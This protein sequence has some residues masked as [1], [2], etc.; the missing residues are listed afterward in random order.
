MAI[1][2]NLNILL[3]V[4]KSKISWLLRDCN[5]QFLIQRD[6]AIGRFCYRIAKGGGET[7]GHTWD[8]RIIFFSAKDIKG[9]LFTLGRMVN[10]VEPL[11]A[12]KPLNPDELP[13]QKLKNALREVKEH[14]AENPFITH[15]PSQSCSLFGSHPGLTAGAF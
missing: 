14:L 2:K 8:F 9:F 15:N 3:G 10:P 13:P 6:C 11:G 12:S 5:I 1:F 4:F 7:E